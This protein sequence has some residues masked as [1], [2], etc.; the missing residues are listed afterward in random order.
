MTQVSGQVTKAYSDDMPRFSDVFVYATAAGDAASI[1][2]TDCYLLKAVGE[3]S[4]GSRIASVLFDV[5][6]M[7]L[8]FRTTEPHVLGPYVLTT[9]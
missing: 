6:G 7:V 8:F 4:H 5:H 3:H 2:Y 1:T 9:N